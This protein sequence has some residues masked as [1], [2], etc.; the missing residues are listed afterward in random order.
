MIERELQAGRDTAEWS[1]ERPEVRPYVKHKL[2]TPFDTERV[3]GVNGYTAYRYKTL[4]KLDAI[5]RVIRVE[6]SNVSQLARLGI[7]SGVLLDSR[8][9]HIVP[10]SASYSEKWQ[11]V[12]EQHEI[13][14]L[15]NQRVLP[16]AWLVTEAEAV[17]GEE[18][19][20]RIRGE[21]TQPFDPRRTALLEVNVNELPALPGGVVRPGSTARISSYEPNRLVIETNAPTPTVLVV[22]EMFYPGWVAIVDGLP[23]DIKLAD[24][25]LRGV[26][27]QSGQHRVEMRYTAPAARIGAIISGITLLLLGALFIYWRYTTRARRNVGIVSQSSNLTSGKT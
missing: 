19:L 14:I 16:R 8:T 5:A 21:S 26:A 9:Q 2:A 23:V 27:L 4:V 24:Y 11:P 17:D 12:Y 6:I 7:Y 13:L 3:G 10:L 25:L 1:H 22:S 18:A 20:R 15:R